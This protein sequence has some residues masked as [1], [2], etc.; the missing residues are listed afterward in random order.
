MLSATAC[1]L[2][3]KAT[4]A[5]L[6]PALQLRRIQSKSTRRWMAEAGSKPGPSLARALSTFALFSLC[7]PNLPFTSV[8]IPLFSPSYFVDVCV[9]PFLWGFLSH[10]SARR[11]VL[12]PKMIGVFGFSFTSYAPG[13]G[14]WGR[15]VAGEDDLYSSRGPRHGAIESWMKI[16]R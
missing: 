13:F 1:L 16:C 2:T 9:R 8:W 10:G 7:C 3:S 6:Y 11:G 14:C 15:K 12:P 4:H 5:V